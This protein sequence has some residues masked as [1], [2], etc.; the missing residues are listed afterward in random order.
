MS[1]YGIVKN[2]IWIQMNQFDLVIIQK[3]PKNEELEISNIGKKN[4][5]K[6]T[7]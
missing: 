7:T 1:E 2:E 6:T 4:Q 3:F 5:Y